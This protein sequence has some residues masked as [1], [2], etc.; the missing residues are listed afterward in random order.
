MDAYSA[1]QHL[2]AQE[3]KANGAV[4]AQLTMRQFDNDDPFEDD[5]SVSVIFDEQVHFENVFSKNKGIHKTE[6]SKNRKP[7]P[8][9]GKKTA[10]PS[11]SMPKM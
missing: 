5:T 1:E 6:S 9:H 10:L 11:Q 7:P 2:I 4:V 3:V 8:K